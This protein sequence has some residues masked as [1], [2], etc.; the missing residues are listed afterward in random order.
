M[1]PDLYIFITFC[2]PLLDFKLFQKLL[3]QLYIALKYKIGL[4]AVG[5]CNMVSQDSFIHFFAKMYFDVGKNISLTVQYVMDA[6]RLVN[7][8]N[9]VCEPFTGFK[10]H[11]IFTTH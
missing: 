4:L 3:C 1:T 10:V 11:E 9:F 6:L 8:I 2:A 5:Q 7:Y